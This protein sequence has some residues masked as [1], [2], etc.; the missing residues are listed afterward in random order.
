M[1]YRVCLRVREGRHTGEARAV[2]YRDLQNKLS[3]TEYV[4]GGCGK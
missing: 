3:L 1:N 4:E 2:V